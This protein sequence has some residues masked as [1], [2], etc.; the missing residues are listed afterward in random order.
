MGSCGLRGWLPGR[1]GMRRGREIKI[2]I[3]I[4]IKI[5]GDGRGINHKK[6]KRRK[7]REKGNHGFHG[8]ARMKRPRARIRN[9]Y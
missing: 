3:T 4:K 9:Y 6:R 2:R 1:W 7:G 8:W 5:Y